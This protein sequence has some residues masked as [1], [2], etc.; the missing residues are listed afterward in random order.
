MDWIYSHVSIYLHT[1]TSSSVLTR[2]LA[3]YKVMCIH[4]VKVEEYGKL[5]QVLCFF[6][7]KLK[8]NYIPS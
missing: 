5:G 1:S 8:L 4:G 6:F 7:I 2:L 3:F